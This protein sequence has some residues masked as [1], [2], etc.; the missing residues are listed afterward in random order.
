M[1]Q[2]F[3]LIA[4]LDITSDLEKETTVNGVSLLPKM[5]FNIESHWLKWLGSLR[6]DEIVNSNLI[7]LCK[8]ETD[9]PDILDGEHKHVQRKVFEFYHALMLYGIPGYQTANMLTGSIDDKGIV[10]IREVASLDYFYVVY[11]GTA[12]KLTSTDIPII[13]RIHKAL[14]TIFDDNTIEDDRYFRLRH[15]LTAYFKAIQEQQNYYRIHQL[16]R[17]IEAIILPKTGK[18]TNQFIHKCKTFVK[19]NPKSETYL[20]EIYELRS[21]VEHLHP[22]NDVYQ[23]LLKNEAIELIDL[24][25]RMVEK[26]ARKSLVNILLNPKLLMFFENNHSIA[27]FW[28]LPDNERELLWGEKISLDNK[29]LD[30]S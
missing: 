18:T 5:L 19:A 26:I 25:V 28:Q 7:L 27:E 15:G 20:R 29:F 23:N 3:S 17:S 8:T 10:S 6:S 24:R 16:V 1:K 22:L 11:N 12:H 4:F 21:K 13:S 30:S 14:M 9:N 2:K